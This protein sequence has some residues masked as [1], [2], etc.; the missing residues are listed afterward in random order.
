MTRVCARVALLLAPLAA[1]ACGVEPTEVLVV[2]DGDL[3]VP[4]DIDGCDVTITGPDGQSG[5]VSYALG[6][7]VA[8]LPFR[9]GL[10]PKKHDDEAFTVEV[11]AFA[12][13][14]AV[15]A[16]AAST[17]FTPHE[18]RVLLL[19]LDRACAGVTCDDPATTCADGACVPIARDPRAL[20]PDGS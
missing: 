14:A 17:A 9:I 16:Q 7:D 12:G 20:P 5:T 4:G 2:V 11:A 10:L 13:D 15:V 8:A 18:T 1:G 19:R 3:G 6:D